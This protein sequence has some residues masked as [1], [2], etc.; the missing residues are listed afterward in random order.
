MKKWLPLSIA[1][2]AFVI[3]ASVQARAPV[4]PSGSPGQPLPGTASPPPGPGLAILNR[5]CTSCHDAAQVTQARPAADW[6]PIL[7]R[8]RNNGANISDGDAKVLLTYL[9]KNYSSRP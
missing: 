1:L 6:Q 9:I 3:S 8:M 7:E 5:S 4:A 2:T